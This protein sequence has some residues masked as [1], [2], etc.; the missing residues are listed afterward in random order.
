[1]MKTLGK[2]HSVLCVL[3]SVLCGLTADIAAGGPKKDRPLDKKLR[4]QFH[5]APGKD[6][7]K[8]N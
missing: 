1:M 3:G 5:V 6:S 2:S 4:Q 7:C 8:N